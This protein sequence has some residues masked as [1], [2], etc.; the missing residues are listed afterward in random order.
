MQRSI[1]IDSFF[2]PELIARY[3]PDILR[4][5]LVTIEVAVLVV[6]TGLL[7]G[8]VLALVRSFHLRFIDILIVVYVDV[9]R[10]LPPLVLVLLV[11]FGLPNVGVDLPSRAVLWLVLSLVLGAFAEE[12]FWAGILSVRKGQWEA[13]RSTGLGFAQTLAYVV[14]PQAIRLTVPPLTN[15]AIAITKNTALGSVIGVPEILN[16][17]TTAESFIGNATPLTMGA[18]AYVLLF[19]PVVLFGRWLETRYAWRRV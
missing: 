3:T 15:R 7:L 17:A 2:K 6:A 9:F 8:L 14:L 13:A 4:A 10:A 18:L 19:I 5:M 1:F 12:I 11:Y 16:V